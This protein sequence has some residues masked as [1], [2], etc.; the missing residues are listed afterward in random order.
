MPGLFAGELRFIYLTLG[1]L[2]IFNF[3]HL[4]INDSR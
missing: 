3:R 2:G 1:T 4:L